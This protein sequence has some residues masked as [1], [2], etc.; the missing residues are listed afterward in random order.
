MTKFESKENLLKG[1][2]QHFS[3]LNSGQL[4]LEEL[5]NLVE[6][7]RELYERALILKFKAYEEKVFGEAK[8]VL[9]ETPTIQ[10]EQTEAESQLENE[11]EQLNEQHEEEKQEL[12]SD[13]PIF[14]FDLFDE[15]EVKPF[16]LEETTTSHEHPTPI[17]EAMAEDKTQIQDESFEVDLVESSPEMEIIEMDEI[18]EPV[19]TAS[20]QTETPIDASQENDATKQEIE[21]VFKAI[22]I[23][24]DSLASRL[25]F[26]KLDT[27]IGSFGFNER[28]QTVQ[29]LFGGSNDDF[30]QALTVL[31]QLPNFDEAKKQLLFY[32]HL[33]KWDLSAQTTIDFIQKIQRRYS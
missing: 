4:T 28:F 17:E 31:D 9:D 13:E 23:Q 1:I 29:E 3:Q 24:D 32:I 30:N 25:M 5:E 21:E 2:E 14:D 10:Q 33:H 8:E 18:A 20:K 19:E 6:Q 26:S 22:L 16:V 11:I 7:T 12:L 27:L 15:E